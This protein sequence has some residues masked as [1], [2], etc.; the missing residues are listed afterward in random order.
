MRPIN[1]I[2]PS[3]PAQAYRTFQILA[4]RSSHRRPATCEETLCRDY[5]NGWRVRVEGLD[6]QMLHSAKTSGRKFTE[7]HVA[8]GENWLVY[9]AGQ[10]CFRVSQHSLPLD[11]QEIFIARDGDFRGNPTGNFRQHTRSEHWLEE[12]GENLDRIR[13]TQERG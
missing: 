11:K 8:E 3:G 2:T 1:R 4:P 6:P 13:A 10:P 12:F 7:L 5:V 9:E